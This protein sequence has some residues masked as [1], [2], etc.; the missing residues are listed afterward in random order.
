MI[1]AS[2]ITV[3]ESWPVAA[4]RRVLWQHSRPMGTDWPVQRPDPGDAFFEKLG[5]NLEIVQ[6]CP[7]NVDLSSLPELDLY[8]YYRH[9]DG[10]TVAKLL[11]KPMPSC[12]ADGAG[13]A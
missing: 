5:N 12:D 4:V 3:H 13:K 7:I 1:D 6:N 8:E 9:A 2:V 10:V 11:T